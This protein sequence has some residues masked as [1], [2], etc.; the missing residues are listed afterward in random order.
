MNK[1]V[2]RGVTLIEL[3]ISVVIGLALVSAA[4]YVYLA[5]QK[6]SRT[7]DASAQQQETANYAL[8]LLGRDLKNAGYYPAS[9]PVTT[10]VINVRGRFENVVNS[11]TPA[12][13]QAVFGCSNAVFN[14]VTGTCPSA[15]T[16]EPDSLVIN[17]FSD[18]TFPTEGRGT[19][20]DCLRQSVETA[21]F[22]AT[23]YNTSRNG[24]STATYTTTVAL[25]V[26]VSNVYSLGGATT[27]TAYQGQSVTTRSLRCA[28]NGSA[29]P[30]P[31]LVGLDQ[32]VVKYGLYETNTN[33]APGRFYTA[34]EVSALAPISVDGNTYTGWARVTSV[35]MCVLTKTL[36]RAARQT[37]NQ[38]S[39]VD[40]N[41][42]TVTYGAADRSLY[43]RDIRLIAV[44]NSIPTSWMF[45]E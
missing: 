1:R 2:N 16:G 17:Y 10:A 3:L 31:I 6:A 25:P 40:C 5:T 21:T 33:R 44:R 29:T 36:D 28:G 45:R 14:P 30:Q 38:G 26:L 8:D 22:S 4:S 7:L 19:R 12:Y 13:S 32:F 42:T 24:S 18:D 20:R 27:T 11:A 23:A 15:T 9:F 34:T 43:K 39:Y 35:Q 41:G 37:A